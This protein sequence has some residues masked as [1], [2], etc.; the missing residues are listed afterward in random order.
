MAGVGR[1]FTAEERSRGGRATQESKR[2]AKKIR[3]KDWDD[4]RDLMLNAGAERVATY[5]TRAAGEGALKDKEFFDQYLK[6]LNYFKPKIQAATI[7]QKGTL[8]I[9]LTSDKNNLLDEI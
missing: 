6:L 7:E 1:E 5:L 2:K 4:L 3:M 9:N 8:N